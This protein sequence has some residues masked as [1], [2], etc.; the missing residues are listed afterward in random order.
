MDTL[1]KPLIF[2]DVRSD[3]EKFDPRLH[4]GTLDPSRI[5]G[6]SEIVQANDIAK[7]DALYFREQNQGRTQEDVYKQIGATPQDL[8]VEFQWL[9]ITGPGGADSPNAQRDL[10]GYVHQQ[11]FRLATEEDLSGR[12][13][14]FPPNARRAEDGSIRRGPDVALYVRSGE[15]SRM[16]EQYR[17]EEAARMENAHEEAE[18]REGDYSTSMT[19]TDER[20]TI[21]VTH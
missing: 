14:G 5:P 21:D 17:A 19:R 1:K 8:D 2:A 3:A 12:G 13:Y 20:E 15:V 10:D 6:Y 9:R 7:A 11:G 4:K 18:F 16:W